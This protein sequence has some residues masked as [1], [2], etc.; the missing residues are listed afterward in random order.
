MFRMEIGVPISRIGLEIITFGPLVPSL[1]EYDG[2]FLGPI[3]D[4]GDGFGQMAREKLRRGVVVHDP[5]LSV[6]GRV[7][8]TG[9]NLRKKSWFIWYIIACLRN[10]IRIL[11][12]KWTFMGRIPRNKVSG[13]PTIVE[14]R[15]LPMP[16][17][18]E[19]QIS[20][21]SPLARL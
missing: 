16:S 21:L 10:Y 1:D 9:Q 20:L 18:P 13:L 17:R 12:Y 5:V 7:I 14:V 2:F 19:F 3:F 6:A 4:D 8:P 15:R 11:K